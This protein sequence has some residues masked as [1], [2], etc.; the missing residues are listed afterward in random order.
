MSYVVN[1]RTMAVVTAGPKVSTPHD[2]GSVFGSRV[3]DFFFAPFV[4]SLTKNRKGRQ[5][6]TWHF[7]KLRNN[8]VSW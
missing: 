3:K 2:F 1:G 4:F 6:R 8:A 5:D 7:G